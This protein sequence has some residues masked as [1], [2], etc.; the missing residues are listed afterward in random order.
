MQTVDAGKSRYIGTVPAVLGFLAALCLSFT[1]LIVS[2]FVVLYC[3]PGYFQGE[4][5]KHDVLNNMP[6]EMTMSRDDGL[7][8]VTDHM[9][10][11]LLFGEKP[12]ELQVEAVI[13]GKKQPFFSKQEL[14]HMWDVRIIFIICIRLALLSLI[15][16]ILILGI[17]RFLIC[18][19][20]PEVFKSSLRGMAAGTIAVITG[21]LGFGYIVSRDFD[22]AF[23][24]MH[25]VLFS[26]R[27]WLMDPR[28]NLLVSIVPEGFFFDTAVCI[29]AVYIVLMLI[30]LILELKMSR[31]NA[32]CL[33]KGV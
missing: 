26:N 21:L 25:L 8:K 9:M 14:S 10:S 12:D 31:K 17:S 3:N 24:N 19:K 28:D 27:D 29:G 22:T 2:V 6:V 11:Y 30:M 32:D 5:E 16:A 1:L 23:L 7:L 15:A 33:R 18:R 4:F 13:N 20:A